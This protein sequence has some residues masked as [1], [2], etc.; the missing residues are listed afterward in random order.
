MHFTFSLLSSC[1]AVFG[2]VHFIL[3]PANALDIAMV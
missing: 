3:D 2:K 1:Q